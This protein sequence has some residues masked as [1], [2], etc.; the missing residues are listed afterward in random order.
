[1][2]HPR[3]IK[4][5]LERPRDSFAWMKALPEK[6]LDKQLADLGFTPA[7][8]GK[9][10]RKHQKVCM[11]VVLAFARFS[12]W[13][14]MG[15]GKTRI[16]LEL[17]RYLFVQGDLSGRVLVLVPSEPAA[18]GWEKQVAD[19]RIGLPVLVLGNSSSKEKRLALAEFERGIIVA[20]YAG[21]TWLVSERKKVAGKRKEKLQWSPKLLKLLLTGVQMAV[22]DESTELGN[23]GALIW[24]ICQQIAKHVPFAYNLAGR[25]F[26]R[27]PIKLWSQQFLI[28][29]GETFGNTLGL[30][31]EAF[32]T[33]KRGHFSMFD[34]KFDE[35]KKDVLAKIMQHR[36]ISYAESECQSLPKVT[37]I[38]EP[39]RL[40]EDAQAY[41]EKAIQAIRAA[42]GN[43]QVTKNVF[44]RMRQIS[45]GFIGFKD[46]E[47]GERAQ[48][49]FA[50]NPKLD[51][52]LELILEMPEDRKFVIFHEYTYSGRRISAALKEAKIRHGWLWGGSKNGRELIHKFDSNPGYR[53][54]VINHKLG[55]MSLNLQS[56]NYQFDYENPV[57]VIDK[58][59]MDKR[60]FREGQTR[61]GFIYELTAEGTMDQRIL[62]FHAQGAD[63][64]NALLRDP[65]KLARKGA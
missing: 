30:F 9:P 36:S 46:D 34:Y 24:K 21:L 26:G 57:S 17:I 65:Y 60:C 41:Y 23:R 12:L 3:A 50:V 52:L 61:P 63:L 62:D 43:Y 48:L 28:D 19:W 38:V 5:L 20:T 56:A 37:R 44:L 8:L 33:K 31:R 55:A 54:L 10:L 11:L 45:S 59:Q 64:M 13:L 25:P 27:D 14:D 15:T 39:I 58:D 47:T 2:I 22:F 29:R 6:A 16:M 4:E 32:Y 42:K 7:R 51:R 40:P 53:G 18:F 35:G 1:M 49:E